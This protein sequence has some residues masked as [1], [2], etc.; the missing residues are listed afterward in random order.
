MSS[1]FVGL[2]AL[3]RTRIIFK[4]TLICTLY[5]AVFLCVF[6]DIANAEKLYVVK[7]RN[8]S[9]TFTSRKPKKGVNYRLYIPKNKRF[10]KPSLRVGR[11]VVIGHRYYSSIRRIAKKQ[12]I[13]PALVKAVVHV[14]SAFNPRA[15]SNKGAMGLMQLMPATALMYGVKNAYNAEENLKGGVR[16]LAMLL[17]R[18]K[19]N[20]TLALAAYNAG[21]GAVDK[22][23]SVPPYKETVDYVKRVK[24]ALEV[25]RCVDAGRNRCS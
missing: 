14:E 11:I 13:E 20:L 12:K 3:K 4:L 18:Y 7:G 16:H 10:S 24:K 9:V 19:G 21:V 1:L 5:S 2:S 22:Y 15:K 17:D 23:S 8:G 6:I 25:Y